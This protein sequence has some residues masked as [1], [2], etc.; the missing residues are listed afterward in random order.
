MFPGVSNGKQFFVVLDPRRRALVCRPNDKTILM[1]ARAPLYCFLVLPPLVLQQKQNVYVEDVK[2]AAA[3]IEK[4]C[5]TLLASKKIDWPNIT[6]NFLKEA[7]S[8]KDADG[9]LLLLTK[10]LAKL[11]DGHAEVR[12]LEKG[13]NS[14]LPAE[15]TAEK[16][17]PGFFLCK[18]ANRIFVKNAWSSAAEAGLQAGFEI[19]KI[20]DKPAL[21]WLKEREA[22][23][24]EMISFSTEQH[25]F[26]Y[27]C[28]WGLA[29]APG[30]RVE[31]ECKDL[32]G[33]I[34]KKT[35]TYTK[36]NPVP[37]GPAFLPDGLDHTKDVHYGKT[38]A[39][40]GYIHIRRCPEDLPAQLDAALEKLANVPGMILDFRGNSGGATDHEALLGRFVPKGTTLKF[41]NRYESAGARPY[42]GP[43]VVIVDATV[44]STGE[45]A[46]GIFKEDGRAYMIGE[47]A[48][49]GMS[50]QKVTINLPS[51]LFSLYVS[52]SSNKGRFNGGRGIEGIGVP[53][54]ETVEFD[55][56]DLANKTD[57]LARRAEAILKDFP[58]GKVPY[59]PA[60]FGWK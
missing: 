23:L 58:K 4:K 27:T 32:S 31:L 30:T 52:V 19:V 11:R 7:Q 34:I 9:H 2:F 12:P 24:V 39:G 5:A 3:E 18:A 14:K 38:P 54:Q 33:K 28:H 42:G 46:S 13:K 36:A 41:T 15:W 47:S 35:V 20:N 50:S 25:S 48:T 6:K 17:G 10:M 60:A 44:R 37:N 55:P 59:D 21:A 49:A 51:G 8:V 26:F 53:P 29:D 45:T 43:I 16:T 22:K 56:K 1:N 40:F 57:T